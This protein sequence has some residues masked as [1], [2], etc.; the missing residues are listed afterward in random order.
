MNVR[1]DLLHGPHSLTGTLF[2]VIDMLRTFNSLWQLRNP[3]K[4]GAFF[5]WR[6]IDAAGNEL[7]LPDWLAQMR[8]PNAGR[9]TLRPSQTALFVPGVQMKSVPDLNH[10][11]DQCTAELNCIARYHA[12]G[13]VIAASFNGAVMLARAGV[14]D[15]R[16]A[17]VTWMIAN[18]FACAFTKV[19][20]A[21]EGPVVVDGPVFTAGAPAAVCDLMVELI[22]HFAGEEMAQVATNGLLYHPMRFEHSSLNFP[23]ISV[24]TRDSVVFRAKQWLQQHIQTPYSLDEVA[25]AATA[26]PRTLLRHFKEVE[27]MTPLDYLHRLRVERAKQ[28]LEVTLIDLT[29][30]MEYCGY[31]DASAFR[32]LFLRST[33]LTPSE[34]RRRYTMRISSRRWRADE[35]GE[36]LIEGLGLE[37]L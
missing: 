12:Q 26:S 3:D 32:R 2:S 4:R 14:L 18:W 29:E 19:Q 10:V 27:G 31:Q 30:V 23:G 20:L 37:R 15:G 17:T 11:L 24:K 8:P 13:R 6:L 9:K 35:A 16:R 33:G 28:L 36:D 21:M 34:Y 7:P 25:Q 1:V 5:H 22:R